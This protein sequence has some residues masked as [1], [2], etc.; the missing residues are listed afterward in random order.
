MKIVFL[1]DDFPPE[2]F[3]GAGISTYELA[4]GMK[5]AGHDVYVITSCRQERDAGESDFEGLHIFKIASNYH[6]RWRSYRSLWNFSVTQTVKKILKEI[7]PDVVHINNVHMHLSFYCFV[8]ARRYAHVVVFTARDTMSVCY[9]K[10]ATKNYLR[11]KDTYTS[12]RD[13]IHQA[14]FR[15]NPFY[16]LLV[17]WFISRAQRRI[18]VSDALK[19]ALLK[20]GIS[21]VE[22]IHTGIDI[23]LW[24]TRREETQ[25]FIDKY[26]LHDKKII[27]H[28]GR[29]SQG[30]GSDALFS[31]LTRIVQAIPEAVLLVV[32]QESDYEK[33]LH[34]EVLKKSVVFTGWVDRETV[35][36]S[37]AVADV[38]VVPSVYLDPF[39]RVVL[40]AMASQKP[41]VGSCYGGSPELII[42]G[43]TGFIVNPL[44]PEE[45][46]HKTIDLLKNSAKAEQFGRNG[47]EI[48]KKDFNL[49]TMVKKYIMLYKIQSEKEKPLHL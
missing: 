23:S 13:H 7:R 6:Q 30:K 17:R 9:G 25:Q 46:A 3:G 45:I 43:A 15:Y 38:V 37:F 10:L 18:S 5:N 14:G 16:T 41:V 32:G 27:L 22:T 34:T 21:E 11:N 4:R 29:L 35:R 26:K 28:N 20:N 47:F 42:D 1:Q 33:K 39:P 24:M 31:A 48:I 2:S 49:E 36:A 44:H 12:V 40:E 8:L 19:D